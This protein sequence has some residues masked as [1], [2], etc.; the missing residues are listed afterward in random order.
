MTYPHF[1]DNASGDLVHVP[2]RHSKLTL[3]VGLSPIQALY[4][5]ASM[6]TE[7]AASA[8]L[9]ATGGSHD[10]QS[11]LERIVE[12]AAANQALN[13]AVNMLRDTGH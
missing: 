12:R 11:M 6:R 2:P 7:A 10:D 4:R 5:Q 9:A 13:L 8:P 1:D 3:L